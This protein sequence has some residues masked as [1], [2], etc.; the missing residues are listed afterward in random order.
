MIKISQVLKLTSPI[1]PSVNHY[2]A[3][4]AIIK[5]GK[6]MAMSYK[7]SEAT[8]YQKDFIKY[9]QEQVKIQNWIKSE[10]KFQHYYMDCIFIFPRTDMDANNY[11]KCMADAI[12]ESGVVWCDDN[13]LC[14]RVQGIYYSSENP[15][16]EMEIRPVNYI[17]VFE[18]TSQLEQFESNC[19]GC[20]RYNRNCSILTKAKEG[21]IQLEL[22]YGVCEKYKP[23]K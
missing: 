22:Q 14:E 17:G 23:I 5:N 20:T 8:K 2:L 15:R 21:R 16:I 18:N 13:Q 9:V 7:T 1:S 11:F 3:Y 6:P 10:N 12:T 4:R 19:I